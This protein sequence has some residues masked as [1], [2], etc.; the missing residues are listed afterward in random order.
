MD[1]V[2]QHEIERVLGGKAKSRHGEDLVE[3]SFQF[4][5]VGAA[6]S[7]VEKGSLVVPK[8]KLRAKFAE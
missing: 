6:H 8:E 3:Q 7:A 1:E 2:L 4:D 5:F